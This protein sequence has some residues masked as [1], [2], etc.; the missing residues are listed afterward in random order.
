MDKLI[1][2][3]KI[4]QMLKGGASYT[5]ISGLLK[6]SDHRIKKVRQ[7]LI[8][9]F[10]REGI[11]YEVMIENIR[12]AKKAQKL[13]D[14]NRIERKAFRNYVKL[15]NAV[16]EYNKELIKIFK[17]YKL[18]KYKEVTSL[19][20]KEPGGIIHLTDLHFNELVN[21]TSNSYDFNIAA[22]RLKLLSIQSKKYFKAFDVKKVLI[23]I[24]GDIL[25][26]DRREDELLNQ[27]VNRARATFLA[28]ALL[29]QFIQDISTTHE[30]SVT[31]VIGNE[32]RIPKDFS[33]TD[34]VA[35]NNYDYTIMKILE[36][37]FKR[38]NI[39][40]LLDGNWVEKIIE[41]NNQ[42][43]LLIHGFQLGGNALSKKIQNIVGKYSTQ[44]IKID[45]VLFGHLHDAR[46]QSFFARGGALVGA[47]AF[48]DAA[49]QLASRATQNIFLIYHD[50]RREGTVI[51]LQK[52]DK[53]E[54]YFIE[55]KLEA[56]HAKSADKAHKKTVVVKVY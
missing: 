35:T 45:Y 6:V 43:I 15:E 4:R 12:L 38:T 31:G 39:K 11:D 24:T 14:T 46:I 32:S 37:I 2:D 3:K 52:V 17:E 44:G 29:E 41:V 55:K 18:P 27:A 42:N 25:N 33:W 23:A 40:F 13:A 30:V 49:L 28:V 19:K 10:K 1:K 26:S 21:I 5:D 9:D 8:E 20:S 50:G 7:Q 56:Y 53:V 48:S 47:N 51:D 54:G 34:N 16:T 22:K 36:L